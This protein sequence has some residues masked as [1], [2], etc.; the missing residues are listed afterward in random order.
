MDLFVSA[1]WIGAAVIDLG[2][3]VRAESFSV[4]SYSLVSWVNSDVLCMSGYAHI[5]RMASEMALVQAAS[6]LGFL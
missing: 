4:F 1:V 6:Q 5:L 3:L 2:L